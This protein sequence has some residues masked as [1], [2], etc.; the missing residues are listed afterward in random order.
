MPEAATHLRSKTLAAWLAV[1]GGTL[2]L[3]RMYLHGLADRWAWLQVPFTALGLIGVHRMLTLGQDD[4]TAWLLLP[5]L[6]LSIAAAMLAAI[7]IALTPDERWNE[8]FNTAHAAVPPSGW[9]AVIA[10]VVALL[11]GGTSLMG[12]VAYG[13]QKLFEW[14]LEDAGSTQNSSR[15]SP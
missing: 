3:H 11:V 12:A 9:G 7:V 1:L 14:Q 2:G 10:A 8:R 4:R 13:G 5:L 6:G 15:L